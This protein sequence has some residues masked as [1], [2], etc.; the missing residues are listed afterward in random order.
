MLFK[1][2]VRTSK[3]TP[4]FTIT[5]INWLTL[6]KEIIAVYSENHTKQAQNTELLIIE[7]GGTY[8]YHWALRGQSTRISKAVKRTEKVLWV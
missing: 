7:V 4:H 1:N 3:R 8:S 5:N 6:F 2:P